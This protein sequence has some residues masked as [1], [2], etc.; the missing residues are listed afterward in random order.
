MIGHKSE[1]KL[2]TE[3]RTL[4]LRDP[5]IAMGHKFTLLHSPAILLRE[6]AVSKHHM[7]VITMLKPNFIA[8]YEAHTSPRRLLTEMIDQNSPDQSNF[9]T[10]FW[11]LLILCQ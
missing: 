8:K 11:L 2:T 10:S 4:V 6:N 3:L 1:V 5:S 7:K 9:F